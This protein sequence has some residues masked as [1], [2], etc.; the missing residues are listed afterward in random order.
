MTP[1][2]SPLTLSALLGLGACGGRP[3]PPAS[4]ASQPATSATEALASM[5]PRKPVPLMPMMAWHQKQNMNDHLAAVQ[6]IVEGTARDD[7]S[8]VAEAAKRIG[9][10]PRM[11]QMCEHMGAGAD[12]FAEAGVEFHR[13]ADGILAAAERADGAGVL[14]AT[15][16]TLSACVSCHATYRQEVVDNETWTQRTAR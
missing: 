7:W 6:A 4:A 13:R 14:A 16:S 3:Q 8:G 9:S 10:S 11:Q 2:L 15:A 12:G 1:K 5:D